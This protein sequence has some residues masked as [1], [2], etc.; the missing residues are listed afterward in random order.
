[1]GTPAE[2]PERPPK[3]EGRGPSQAPASPDGQ[4]ALVHGLARWTREHPLFAWMDGMS[5]GRAVRWLLWLSAISIALAGLALAGLGALAGFWALGE[6]HSSMVHPLERMQAGLENAAAS[7]SGAAGLGGNLS[8]AAQAASSGL[9]NLSAGAEGMAATIEAVSK[10]PFVGGASGAAE[11]AAQMRAYGLQMNQAAE[12]LGG[13][14]QSGD[15]MAAALS[16]LS[17]DL[18]QMG[19]GVAESRERLSGAF[20][21]LRAADLLAGAALGAMM[22]AVVMLAFAYGPPK[23]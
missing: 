18:R 10:I 12:R 1:M 7:A 2:N 23:G 21:L 22:G 20:L 6:M 4:D 17:D 16:S 8:L 11:S 14:G 3:E 15:A 5:L 9:T 19:A 13:A